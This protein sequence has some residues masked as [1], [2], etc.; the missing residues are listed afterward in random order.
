M[1]MEKKKNV[2]VILYVFILT[3]LGN[4][5]KILLKLFIRELDNE[6]RFE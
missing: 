5:L 4:I 2:Y 1:F 6:G 3:T